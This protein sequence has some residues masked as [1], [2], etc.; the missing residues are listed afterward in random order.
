MDVNYQDPKLSGQMHCLANRP[1]SQ[2]IGWFS[3][4][5]LCI[6]DKSKNIFIFFQK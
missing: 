2:T 1:E 5:F 6:F 4:M 3:L